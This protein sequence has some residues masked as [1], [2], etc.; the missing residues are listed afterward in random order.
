MI[1]YRPVGLGELEKIA[2]SG[3]R[4]FPPRFVW[5]PIFY[6]V[7]SVEYA[8][9]IIRSWNSREEEAGFCGF[10]TEFDIDDEFVTRDPPQEAGG[11]E[12][13]ELWVP[14]E[15]LPEFNRHILGEIRVIERHYGDDFTGTLDPETGLPQSVIDADR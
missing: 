4:E 12:F 14:A 9:A 7:L 8:R 11:R 1:L 5:Q 2:A 3:Y 6:P 10:I 15:D 13:R